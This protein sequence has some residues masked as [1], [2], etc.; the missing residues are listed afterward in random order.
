MLLYRHL[1]PNGET[2]YIGVGN[3]IRP[4]TKSDRNNLW[5]KV[6]KKYGYEIQ[7][8]KTDLTKTEAYELETILVAWY[9]R[10]NL[11]L[12]PL[13][14]LTD[15]GDGSNN[16]VVSENTREKLRI[17]R[18]GY[19]LSEETKLKISN[20]HKGKIVSEETRL[21]MSESGKKKVFTEEHY[22]KLHTSQ[23]GE[24]N[25]MF[26]KTHSDETKEKMRQKALGRKLSDESKSKI[27]KIVLHLET[28]VFFNSIREAHICLN[29]SSSEFR[30]QITNQN[31][32]KTG[33]ILV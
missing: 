13:V 28:G 31:P 6:V 2:F 20:S 9:G 21:K 3:N 22:N 10:R 15:G 26:G 32:N 19:T 30:R 4:Y 8:L 24:N 5:W 18:L 17:A 11:E 12:G 16:V 14:N 27:S 1:K 25:G 33:C 23:K 7:I 29:Y